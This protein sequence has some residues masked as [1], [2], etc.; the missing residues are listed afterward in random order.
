MRTYDPLSC[1]D[2]IR[3]LCAMRDE[4]GRTEGTT[5]ALFLLLQDAATGLACTAIT[6]RDLER[7]IQQLRNALDGGLD[8]YGLDGDPR[9]IHVPERRE[10]EGS[11]VDA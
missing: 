8:R 7:Q 9:E 11:W 5:C 3:A 6:R 4:V 10:V 1:T 2:L